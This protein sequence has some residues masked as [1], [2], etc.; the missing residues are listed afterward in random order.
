[1]FFLGPCFALFL[2]AGAAPFTP[3]ARGSQPEVPR[4]YQ[5]KAVFLFN[6][7]KFVEWPAT[8]FPDAEAPLRLCVLGEDPF[9][10]ALEETVRGESIADRTL[11][12]ERS[13]QVDDLKD[14]QLL[15]ISRSERDRVATILSQLG[16]GAVLTVSEVE[17]FTRR[18]GIIN[19][20]LDGNR[21]RFEINQASAR[22]MGLKIDAQLLSLAKI[23][24]TEGN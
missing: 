16:P 13:R 24:E 21:V 4:E 18:G 2:A 10:A 15:F 19:F 14:C 22:R 23:V 8:A 11:A 6:F 7:A 5:I 1:V 9:G 20:Y 12:I 17:D 3:T